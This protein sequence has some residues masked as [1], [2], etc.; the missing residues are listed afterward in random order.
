[1]TLRDQVLKTMDRFGMIGQPGYEGI[2]PD[3][4]EGGDS[5]HRMGHYHFLLEVNKKLGYDIGEINDLPKRTRMD[6]ETVLSR[7]EAGG[8]WGNYRRHY[9][10]ESS[11]NGWTAHV[12]TTYGGNMSRDQSQALILGMSMRG[13]LKHSLKH[14]LRH[15]MRGFIFTNQDLK[16]GQDPSNPENLNFFKQADLTGP[17]YWAILIRSIPLLGLILYPLLCIFDIET[18]IGSIIRRFQKV[19][20]D[21]DVANHCSICIHGMMKWPTPTMYLANK[22]NSY[23]DMK[24]KQQSYWS[25]WRQQPYFVELY[26]RP[27]R[28]YFGK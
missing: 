28:K 20:T 25:T 13:R 1:M 23:E 18:V 10:P 19:E 26:D 6:Y 22:I 5:A 11:I 14:T 27:M 2:L 15:A 16:N 24:K 7:L 12:G 3:G 9:R 17:E 4:L 8:S 21:D